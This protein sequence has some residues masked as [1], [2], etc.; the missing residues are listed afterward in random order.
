MITRK[1]DSLKLEVK[2]YCELLWNHVL[3]QQGVLNR[4]KITYY[5][6]STWINLKIHEVSDFSD[7]QFL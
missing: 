7:S 2:M 6:A 4:L 5:I 3:I 1:E